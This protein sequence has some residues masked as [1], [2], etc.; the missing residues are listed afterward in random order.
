MFR[1]DGFPFG[2]ENSWFHLGLRSDYHDQRVEAA[3]SLRKRAEVRRTLQRKYVETGALTREGE[4]I[5]GGG[6]LYRVVSGEAQVV[7]EE[8]IERGQIVGGH[9]N[10]MKKNVKEI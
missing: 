1:D 9:V 7:V 3:Q 8:M 5:F 2:P 10:T 6:E 4:Y